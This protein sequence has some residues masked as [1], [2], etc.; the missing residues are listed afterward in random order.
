MKRICP[1]ILATSADD[2]LLVDIRERFEFNTYRADF[3]NYINIPFSEFDEE[4]SA[5]DKSRKLILICNNGLRSRTAVQF[6]TERGFADVASVTGGLVKWKQNNLAMT[7]TPP[8]F[9]SHSLSL[10]KDCPT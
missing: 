2:F 1:S 7:G 6:L 8:D 3:R 9:I 5:L 10:S 4:L